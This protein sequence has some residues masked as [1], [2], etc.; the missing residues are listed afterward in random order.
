M[1]RLSRCPRE[2]SD[3]FPADGIS[4]CLKTAIVASPDPNAKLLAMNVAMSSAMEIAHKVQ[5]V[6]RVGRTLSAR[7]QQCC[8]IHAKSFV[9]RI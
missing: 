4:S 7:L 8:L 2:L 5:R 9:R 3:A 1:F 6:T